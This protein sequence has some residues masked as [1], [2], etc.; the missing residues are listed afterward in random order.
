MQLQSL[1]LPKTPFIQIVLN[2][3]LSNVHL[4]TCNAVRVCNDCDGNA[5]K[6]FPP[7]LTL[8][9]LPPIPENAITS[10]VF[11]L[12]PYMDSLNNDIKPINAPAFSTS[13][14]L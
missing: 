1:R 13:I 6:R 9:K 14:R 2:R 10:I 5:G 11:I 12:L 7:K 3:C 8:V 4:I